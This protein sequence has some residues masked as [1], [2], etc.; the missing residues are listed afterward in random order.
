MLLFRISCGISQKDC[1]RPRLP[2]TLASIK[3][4]WRATSVSSRIHPEDSSPS[5]NLDETFDWDQD[6][7]RSQAVPSDVISEVSLLVSN[8]AGDRHF[9]GSTSGVLF[10]KLVRES[11][12]LTGSTGSLKA[13]T[14]K[15]PY[16]ATD[17]RV[18]STA[19][20]KSG[21]DALPPEEFARRLMHWYLLHDHLAYPFL[22][23]SFLLSILE[24]VYNEPSYY[25]ENHFGA[26]AFDMVL[27]VATISVCKY[28]WQIPGA[29][30]HY[31][32]AMT[33]IED[34]FQ[35]GSLESLQAILLVCQ[36]RIGSSAQDTS[37]SM[38][39]LVGIAVR[40]AYELGLHHESGYSI[41]S[42]L[43]G[44][45]L[46][47]KIK[48]QEVRRRCYW[49]VFC[50]DRIVSISLGRPFAIN[51]DNFDV[52]LPSSKHDDILDE[53]LFPQDRE[54]GRTSVSAH[55]I[56]Y[57]LLCGKIKGSLHGLRRSRYNTEHDILA[58]RDGL[59]AELDRWWGR[60]PLLGLPIATEQ[61]QPVPTFQSR[62]WYEVLYHNAQLM[63]FRPSPMLANVSK[64]PRTLQ[65]IF[66]SS[67]KSVNLYASL[68]RSKKINYSWVTLHSVFMAGL[69]YMYAVSRHLRERRRQLAI[70]AMLTSDPSTIE[71][72]HD[73]RACSNVLVAVS[74][75]WNAFRNCHEVFDRLSDAVLEDSIKL[76]G[77][78]LSMPIPQAMEVH[79]GHSDGVNR[80]AQPDTNL[81]HGG[82]AP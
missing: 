82:S 42:C 64:D 32:R 25:N 36:Y 35:A 69:S 39:H 44:P 7:D 77:A 53:G 46:V 57:R 73:T 29:E 74:E 78:H 81:G 48:E 66:L 76:Q 10:A 2:Q 65:Q 41:P 79:V 52:D 33:R 3:D 13:Q 26:F 22:L 75:R 80:V 37:T 38:W 9:L 15:D 47:L 6:P 58:L 11:V 54:I 72:V 59:S 18:S 4:P 67:K 61:D 24:R 28:N 23:P 55:I 14:F 5:A 50:M 12:N 45:E 62:E 68:H 31:I 17:T 1:P 16:N 43:S 56:E 70:G 71:I 30:T 8:A 40:T 60:T 19:I 21:S 20:V 34:V 27:P 49:S 63:L 51:L